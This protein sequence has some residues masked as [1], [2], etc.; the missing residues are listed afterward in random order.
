[1]RAIPLRAWVLAAVSA[2]LQVMPFSIAGPVPL[3]RRLFCWFC[4]V[5]LLVALL[6]DNR[7]GKALRPRQTAML[8]YLCG[9]L[10]YLG[11]CY[12]I[13]PTMYLYGGIPKPASIG[14]LLLFALYLGLYHA[15]FGFAIGA[16]RQRF[17]RNTILL[18]APVIW[19]AVEL[20]RGRIT[21]FP[22]DLLGYTQVD[23][24]RLSG[25]AAWTG[26]MGLSL[27][28]A[29]VN[30]CWLL[31]PLGPKLRYLGPAAAI[32]CVV[33]T[34]VLLLGSRSVPPTPHDASAVLLQENLSVGK[35][36]GERTETKQQLLASFSALSL[37]AAATGLLE[38]PKVVIWPEAP[39]DFYDADPEFRE[40]LASVAKRS[41]SPVIVDSIAIGPRAENGAEQIYNSANFFAADGTYAGRYDKMHLVPFGEYTPYKEFFFF[42]GHLLDNVGPFIPGSERR[43]FS[44]GGHH[45]GVFIC[46]ESIFGDEI[47]QF[48]QMD[49]DVLVNISDDGWY[50]DTSAPWEHLDMVRMR[51]IEN[52]RWIVRATNTGV[53]ASIDPHGRIV[54]QMERHQ[55]GAIDAP[56]GY[57]TDHTFY[58]RYG[59]WLAWLCAL[60]SVVAVAA[61][62]RR[63]GTV[64]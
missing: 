13:Y 15:L 56:F 1:M 33:L 11:N 58:T 17:L 42:A 52:H 47:R 6:G 62:F 51:A 21:G 39:T 63:P 57:L 4:L 40:A 19:V 22:W 25:I 31:K 35:Q 2:V 23:N 36:G 46:Y 53:T 44:A 59:D 26:A 32:L 28:I 24:F 7:N 48:A 49:A 16:L 41:G 29:W 5:P 45:Y 10:W 60:A 30:A 38:K 64:N 50:G 9:V 61:S 34:T 3:W 18:L 27:L 12:W 37:Q 8:G 55:R 20:A 54:A 14:I 43:V